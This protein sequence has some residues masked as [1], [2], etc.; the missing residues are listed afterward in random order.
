MVQLIEPFRCR[1][2]MPSADGK[3]NGSPSDFCAFEFPGC[4][5]CKFA[6]HAIKTLSP[7]EDPMTSPALRGLAE[8]ESG[9]LTACG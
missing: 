6:L 9:A 5:G 1:F 7:F 4:R 2:E 3:F 8:P